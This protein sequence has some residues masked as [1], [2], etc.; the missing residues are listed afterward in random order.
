[1]PSDAVD[2]EVGAAGAASRRR[3]HAAAGRAQGGQ[4]RLVHAVVV[5][6]ATRRPGRRARPA[7]RRRRAR[8]RRCRPLPTSSSDAR[9]R[10][11]RPAAARRSAVRPAAARAISAPSGSASSSGCSAAR[12][13]STSYAGASAPQPSATTTAEA[14]PAS[15][16]SET[17]QAAHAELLGARSATVAVTVRCG[18]PSSPRCTSASRHRSPTG[19][20]ERLGEGLLGR[21]ACGERGGRQLLLRLGE[22]PLGEARRARERGREAGDV[23][24]VDADSDDHG[25]T[26]A[27]RAG[28]LTRR[29]APTVPRSR[30]SPAP[31]WTSTNR[32]PPSW[33]NVEPANSS[34]VRPTMTV[35]GDREQLAVAGQPAEEV[36]VWSLS[37]Q[38]ISVPRGLVVTLSGKSSVSRPG[39]SKSSVQLLGATVSKRP[40]LTPAGAEPGDRVVVARGAGAPPWV[41]VK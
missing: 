21:E 19:A 7:R 14:M 37:S 12:T 20:P 11:R 4:A 9:R 5:R 34:P 3:R 23:D 24:D 26:L 40:D 15:W 29:C 32:C 13:D 36:V 16:L 25:S 39:D 8:R 18:R 1:M 27:R 35:L 6:A 33:L 30:R 41:E 10:R 17:M 38:T 2:D 31:A 22:E 28:T